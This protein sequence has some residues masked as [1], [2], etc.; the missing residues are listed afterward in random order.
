MAG[1]P[2]LLALTKFVTENGLTDNPKQ[3]VYILNDYFCSKINKICTEL[4]TRDSCDP[5]A[6]LKHNFD[7][8]NGWI[9]SIFL[10]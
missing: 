10:N 2:S 8:W 7:R 1:W 6:L 4:E 3:M 5:L 9:M